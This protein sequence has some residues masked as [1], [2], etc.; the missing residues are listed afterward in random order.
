[1]LTEE[2]LKRSSVNSFDQELYVCFKNKE[3]NLIFFKK[4]YL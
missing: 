1:M 2:N 4:L 3:I